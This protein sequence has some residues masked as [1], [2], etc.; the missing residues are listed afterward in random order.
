MFPVD[1]KESSEQGVWL[2]VANRFYPNCL[3]NHLKFH[4]R[5]L[6]LVGV[7]T[8]LSEPNSFS[9]LT[10]HY[11]FRLGGRSTGVRLKLCAQ[12]REF[13]FGEGSR[14]LPFESSDSATN[15][16]SNIVRCDGHARLS[17]GE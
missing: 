5:K 3:G 17:K 2:V 16:V 14:N 9:N 8:T 10:A 15:S 13:L 11:S 12:R 1:E 6:S 7:L 4:F